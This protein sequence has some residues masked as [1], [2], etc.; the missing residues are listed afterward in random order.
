LRELEWGYLKNW[1]NDSEGRTWLSGYAKASGLDEQLVTSIV[2]PMLAEAD[3]Q[4]RRM[5]EGD[6]EEV[7]LIASGPQA[8]VPPATQ[9]Q[10]EPRRHWKWWMRWAAAS[11]ASIAIIGMVVMLA[12]PHPTV[13]ARIEPAAPAYRAPVPVP[14]SIVAPASAPVPAV[15]HA[16]YKP[17]VSKAR[18]SVKRISAPTHKSSSKPNFFKRQLLRIVIK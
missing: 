11:A 9:R 18:T 12:W 10:P 17:H 5:S 1:R 7:A 4:P 3:P 8:L 15:Q 13:Q 14:A 2:V 6:F 16:V